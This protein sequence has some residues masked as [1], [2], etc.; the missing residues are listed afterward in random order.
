MSMELGR[1]I[2]SCSDPAI[3]MLRMGSNGR[4]M[5]SVQRSGVGVVSQAKSKTLRHGDVVE[6]LS[7]D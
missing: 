7:R 6:E 5:T 4:T 1:R 3:G 2:H